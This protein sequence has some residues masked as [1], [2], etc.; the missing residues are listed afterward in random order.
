MVNVSREL[1]TADDTSI[2]E[3][4]G[5]GCLSACHK[6]KYVILPKTKTILTEANTCHA[7]AYLPSPF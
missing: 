4:T 1:E 6:K 2:Y 5:R 3:M 7:K